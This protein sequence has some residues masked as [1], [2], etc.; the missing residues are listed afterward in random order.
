MFEPK[1][2]GL[3]VG[4]YELLTRL[5][6]GGMGEVFIARRTGAGAF[7]KKL[8]L[9]LLLPHL[10]P[11]QE[12][13]QRF[14]DEARLAARMNHP[15]IVQI[16]DVGE[17][18]G[19]P[20][21]AMALVEGISLARFLRV[22]RVKQTQLPMPIVRLIAT[23]LLEA[24]AYAH[25]LKGS[26]GE[27][28]GVI[29]RDV[30]P[31]NLLLSV[32]G[33]VMLNDFGIAKAAINEHQTRPGTVRGKFAYVAPEQAHR[34]RLT[35]R[36]DLFSAAVTIYETLTLVS[37]FAH[38]GDVQTMDA[39]VK[40]DPPSA[41]K[42]RA[43]VSEQMSR[44]LE[45][46]MSKKPEDR[47]ASARQFREALADGPVATQ[48]ELGD[49]VQRLCGDDLKVFEKLHGADLS[50]GTASLQLAPAASP[51]GSITAPQRSSVKPLLW[52]GASAV[53]GFGAVVFLLKQPAPPVPVVVVEPEAEPEPEPEPE[54]APA[55][56]ESAP[57][58]A[59]ARPAQRPR[60]VLARPNAEVLRV[61][62]LSADADPWATVMLDGRL[63]DRTPLSRYPVPVGRHTLVFKSADGAEQTRVL[64][65]EE[66]K[67][68]TLRVEFP[69]K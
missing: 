2:N 50:S 18:D 44:A 22:L 39:V 29:H 66:G 16:F 62:Y 61:G 24:L 43:E 60:P 58:P 59:P 20:Y 25:T 30:T 10:V 54:P 15:N 31:S 13:V 51:S 64:N 36:A 47:Y 17:S 40:L 46:A 12:F 37:P 3:R 63:L 65:V 68:V 35:L 1:D 7:E 26:R 49:W 45:R 21:L 55:A 28:L 69:E 67:V 4:P 11:D 14:F 42:L 53:V 6:S 32:A 8:A 34:G 52:L 33:S 56:A 48:P 27:E 5:A 19:R 57:A 9:K 38:A 41:R 23:G